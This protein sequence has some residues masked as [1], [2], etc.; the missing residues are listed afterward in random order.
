MR[1]QGTEQGIQVMG[2]EHVTTSGTQTT[3]PAGI[4]RLAIV[5]V[6]YK[7]QK[8]LADL[9]ASFEQLTCAPWRI[10]IV[11]NENA[12]QTEQMVAD[13][14]RR[15]EKLWGA[16]DADAKGEHNRAVYAPQTENLGGAGGFSA[17]VRCAFERGASWFWVMDDDVTVMPDGI[18]KLAHWID[19]FDVIQGSRLDFDGGDFYWQYQFLTALGIPNPIAKADLGPEGFRPMNQLCFEGGMFSRRVVETIG[20]PDFR[21]FIYGDDAVYGY[22][23]SKHF[24]AA[25]VA[26]VVLRRA[27]VV[28]NW[29]I[30][31]KRQLNSTSDNNRYYIMRNRGFTARYLRVCGDYHRVLYGVGT[32][33]TFAKELIRL[34][35][36]DRTFKTGIPALVRGMRDARKILRDRDWQPMPPLGGQHD[37]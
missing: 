23:A 31:G 14:N 22:L 32:A 11:D 1:R 15:L 17:G 37:A 33:A 35:A 4:P 8:L 25:V 19:R 5:V 30:A 12:S 34:I 24:P 7:R 9:F 26:D 36:V 28:S 20:L 3:M 18:E 6:T 21:Y 29:D 27:R 2:T 10:V 13:L 16:A